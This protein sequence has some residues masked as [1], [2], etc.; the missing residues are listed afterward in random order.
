M[1]KNMKKKEIKCKITDII[2]NEK[3]HITNGEVWFIDPKTNMKVTL[4]D[5]YNYI[6]KEVE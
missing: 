2:L 5:S 1:S 3:Y 6:E 4:R